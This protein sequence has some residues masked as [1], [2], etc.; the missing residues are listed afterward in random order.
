MATITEYA[1]NAIMLQNPKPQKVRGRKIL[2]GMGV[3]YLD[4]ATDEYISRMAEYADNVYETAT[5][6]LNDSDWF[7]YTPIRIRAIQATMQGYTSELM[8]DDWKQ[9]YIISPK[10][11]RYISQGA[12]M[13]FAENWWIVYKPKNMDSPVAHAVVR[14]CNTVINKLDYYGNIVSLPMSFGKMGTLGNSSHASEN[15]IVSKNY[16]DCIIQKN[17]YTSEFEEN[18]RLILGKSAYM[19]RGLNDFTREQTN[20]P[21][22][23]HLLTF[24]IERTTPLEQDDMEKQVADYKGFS[25]KLRLSANDKMNP[26][27]TEPLSVVS[28]RNNQIVTGTDEHPIHYLYESSDT[29]VVTIDNYGNIRAIDEGQATITVTLA[30]NTDVSESIDIT[31][32]NSG[33]SFVQFT[34]TPTNSI[35]EL[36]SA[37][38][39]AA[40]FNN[41]AATDNAVTFTVS[42]AE[43]SAYSYEINGNQITIYC[44]HSTMKPLTLTATCADASASTSITLTN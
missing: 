21:D 29:D 2:Q 7:K 11:I 23:V 19:I 26:N 15:S 32:S 38:Y 27:G 5:Q 10:G 24:T 4:E 22:S 16:M 13:Y 39:S 28:V 9:I 17:K 43:D 44:Y 31:V 25:W 14:R 1:K 35:K 3:P 30:E 8:P 20:D 40:Y 18:T 37:T 42:G 34:N 36:S 33:E 41:G 12:Y 6:S